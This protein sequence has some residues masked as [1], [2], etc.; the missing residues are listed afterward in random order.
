MCI[1]CYKRISVLCVRIVGRADV[2]VWFERLN[3]KMVHGV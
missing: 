3:G 1:V 2:S